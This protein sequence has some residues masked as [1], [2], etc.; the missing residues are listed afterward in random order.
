MRVLR[1]LRLLVSSVF[2]WLF[3]ITAWV[4]ALPLK[5]VVGKL[6]KSS[7]LGNLINSLSSS[8]AT[9]RGL[10]LLIGSGLLCLS[11]VSTFA[12]FGILVSV[13]GFDS[14]LY[15]FCIPATILHVGVL[16]GFVGIMLA[17]PLGQGYKD[18]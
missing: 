6:D 14:R 8:M 11:L 10:L 17:V 18:Q 13:A 3:R 1:L 12:V 4:F 2:Q 9:Q 15:L 7:R 5:P 16:T